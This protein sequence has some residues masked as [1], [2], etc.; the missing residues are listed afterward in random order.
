[1]LDVASVGVNLTPKEPLAQISSRAEN[2]GLIARDAFSSN[3]KN[4][5]R[6][7]GHATPEPVSRNTHETKT[8]ILEAKNEGLVQ[9]IFLF[10]LVIFWFQ[11]FVFWGVRLHGGEKSLI[12]RPYM[13]LEGGLALE[14]ELV[15]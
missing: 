6:G 15:P 8:N 5:N 11:P 13:S 3:K 14:V 12:I 9:M 10:K 1:M 2:G 4:M 7:H